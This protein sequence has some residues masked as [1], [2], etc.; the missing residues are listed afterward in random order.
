MQKRR[1]CQHAHGIKHSLGILSAGIKLMQFVLATFESHLTL[2][3]C[4]TTARTSGPPS[5][6]TSVFLILFRVSAA[7][8]RRGSAQIREFLLCSAQQRAHLTP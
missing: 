7:A 3:I 1:A 4:V 6:F 2:V 5:L 8:S